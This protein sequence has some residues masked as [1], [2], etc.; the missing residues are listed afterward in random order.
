MSQFKKYWRNKF[1]NDFCEDCLKKIKEENEKYYEEKKA[2]YEKFKEENTDMAS[3]RKLKKILRFRTHSK[4]TRKKGRKPK[5]NNIPRPQPIVRVKKIIIEEPHEEATL[6]NNNIN[7]NNESNYYTP[8]KADGY[9]GPHENSE[10][11]KKAKVTIVEGSA[12]NFTPTLGPI[13][14]RSTIDKSNE[15]IS[16]DETDT[17]F[18]DV[19]QLAVTM[20]GMIKS[21]GEKPVSEIIT[22][23]M[24]SEPFCK[25]PVLKD[26]LV[27]EYKDEIN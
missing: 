22:D 16:D 25:Y 8:E 6:Q 11:F 15:V 13:N 19:Y 4:K 9:V 14:P 23:I 5:Q 17:R 2:N 27:S 21:I 1:E 12:E 18:D 20:L 24:K 26:K 3:I 7:N 10:T